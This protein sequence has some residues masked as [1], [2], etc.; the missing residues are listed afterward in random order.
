MCKILFSDFGLNSSVAVYI[1]FSASFWGGKNKSEKQ[2]QIPN[3]PQVQK[4]IYT[5]FFNVR[6]IHVHSGNTGKNR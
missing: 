6:V 5:Y 2:A 4:N 3:P 1:I